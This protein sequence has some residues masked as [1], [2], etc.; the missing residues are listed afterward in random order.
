MT[1]TV[2]LAGRRKAS[3]KQGDDVTLARF[4]KTP[5]EADTRPRQL[6]LDTRHPA[7]MDGRR[8]APHARLAGGHQRT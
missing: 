5:G 2:M 8:P 1:K 4:V 7:Y 3:A 6:A